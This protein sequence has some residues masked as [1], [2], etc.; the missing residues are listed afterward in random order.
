MAALIDESAGDLICTGSKIWTTHAMEANWI[1][2]LVRTTRGE[3]K[4]QGITFVLIDMKF[5]I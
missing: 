1:F 2:A 4:Q 5:F 3:R